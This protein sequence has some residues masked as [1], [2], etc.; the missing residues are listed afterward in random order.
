MYRD[1]F[2]DKEE[3]LDIKV[4]LDDGVLCDVEMQ[5]VPYDNL[6]KRILDYWA[7]LYRTNSKRGKNYSELRKTIVILISRFELEKTKDY[8]QYQTRWKIMEEKLMIELTDLLEIDI[9]ELPK[10]RKAR[11]KGVFS[12][13][14]NLN[15]WMD[16]FINPKMGANLMNDEELDEK[17]KRAYEE[18]D[19]LNQNEEERED[20]R[21][22]YLNLMSFKEQ[23]EHA[24]EE[25]LKEGKEEGIREGRKEGIKEGIKENSI[26]I[27]RKMKLEK[28]DME[29][30][31]KITGISKEE[32]EKL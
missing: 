29:L 13:F 24:R 5:V 19:R 18:W 14:G 7:K 6:D 26:E 30:I 27:A 9:I 23:R 1:F 10:V 4:E 15:E 31:E 32:I 8:I 25:G 2:K 16:F 21:T 20:A 22:R 28:M 17:I 12:G 11:K 3:V